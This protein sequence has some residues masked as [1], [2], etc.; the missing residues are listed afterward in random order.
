MKSLLVAVVASFLV[1]S[2]VWRVQLTMLV[3][4]GKAW[5]ELLQEMK[6]TYCK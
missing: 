2:A 3:Q 5:Y 4:A 1:L 6:C